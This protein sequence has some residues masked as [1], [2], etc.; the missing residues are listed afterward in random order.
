MLHVQPVAY[1]VHLL[2]GARQEAHSV[3]YM[4][5]VLFTD[6]CLLCLEMRQKQNSSGVP[7]QN[8]ELRNDKM[9]SKGSEKVE[10]QYAHSDL[11][12]C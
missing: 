1:F 10:D 11:I 3:S 8:N 2:F 7:N 4:F 5:Y 12:H 6:S 9:L